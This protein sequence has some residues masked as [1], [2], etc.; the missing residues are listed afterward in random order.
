MAR[1]TTGMGDNRQA[2]LASPRSGANGREGWKAKW[3]LSAGQL[4]KRTLTAATT[5]IGAP[6]LPRWLT[7]MLCYA[8][9]RSKNTGE[10][11]VKTKR[12]FAIQ[13]NFKKGRWID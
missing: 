9:E 1:L 7:T 11:C 5:E 12:G 2:A 10:R 13:E 8:S 6:L 3:Q 4:D